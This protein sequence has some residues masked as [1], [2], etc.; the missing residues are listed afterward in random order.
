MLIVRLPRKAAK[1][2]RHLCSVVLEA[3]T[4]CHGAAREVEEQAQ[5]R[6]HLYV[7]TER[8]KMYNTKIALL[9]E[10]IKVLE[11]EDVHYSLPTMKARDGIAG[12]ASRPSSTLGL[13]ALSVSPLPLAD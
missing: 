13:D 12:R 1:T 3:E 7:G 10:V 8:G 6:T 2:S 9:K 5:L 4:P 11:T